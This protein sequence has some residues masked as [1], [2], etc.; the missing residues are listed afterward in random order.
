MDILSLV[1]EMTIE[2]R[3]NFEK[4]AELIS[5]PGESGEARE[6]AL[7]DVL[8]RYLPQ[9]CGIATGFVI[10]SNW[11]ESLQMD[12]IIYDKNY[13]PVFEVTGD[14]RYFPCET[15]LAVGEVKTSIDTS[16]LE[17]SFKKIASAKALERAGSDKMIGPGATMGTLERDEYYD[18]IFGFIF[19]SNSLKEQNLLETYEDLLIERERYLWPNYYCDYNN[20]NI[21][22]HGIYDGSRQFGGDPMKAEG[23]YATTYEELLFGLFHALLS[24]RLSLTSIGRPNLFKYYNIEQL[25]NVGYRFFEEEE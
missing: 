1:Q 4:K 9:R 8:R 23:T 25:I 18:Q 7:K 13:S 22:Y 17:D 12:I 19:T 21:G 24:W 11:R 3:Q 16:E 2:L 10:D 14:K 20:I 5:H 15:V 6:E